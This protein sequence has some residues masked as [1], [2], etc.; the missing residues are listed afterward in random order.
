MNSWHSQRC[1]KQYSSNSLYA[2][3]YKREDTHCCKKRL[4]IP[5]GWP[6]AVNLRTDTTM[7][8]RKSTNN[9]L[10]NTTQKTKDRATGTPLKI[11]IY[12][13]NNSILIQ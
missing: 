9:D 6:E 7:V 3:L 12:Y 10:Q 2:I 11:I 13:I 8:K 4:K 1:H 5:N